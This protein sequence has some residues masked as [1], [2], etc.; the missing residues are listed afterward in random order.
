[1]RRRSRLVRTSLLVAA[2][3]LTPASALAAERVEEPFTSASPQ[4][5]VLPSLVKIKVPLPANTA[6]HPAACD[7][8]QYVRW[9][10]ADGPTSSM[11]ADAVAVLMPGILEG[12]MAFDVLARNVVRAAAREGRHVEVWGLDR[13]ANC[14]EDLTGVNAYEQSG[15]LS[16]VLG[17]YWHGKSV[18]GK[19]FAGFDRYNRVLRDIGMAQT[20][21]DYYSVL[22][23]E[24]PSQPWRESHV[25]CGGHSLG[26]PITQIFAG[27]DFDGN[28]ATTDDAGYR[29]C[30]GFVGFESTLDLDP[31]N[32]TPW[33]KGL[34]GAVFLGNYG[35]ARQAGNA[36]IKAGLLP[37]RAD[38]GGAD[39]RSS[40]FL[41]AAGIGASRD[42]NGEATALLKGIPYSKT[43]YDYFHFM[44]SSSI[45]SLMFTKDSIR[46]YRYT[47]MGLVGQLLDDNGAPFSAVRSSFGFFDGAP[48]RRNLLPKQMGQIPVVDWAFQ[49]NQMY[50]P[51]KPN[52]KTPLLGWKNYDQVG[53]PGQ[54][55]YKLTTPST[56]VSDANDIARILHEGPTNFTEPYM[57]MR[58]LTDL[59]S[60]Y[61]GDRGGDLAGFTYQHPTAKKP[62]MESLGKSGVA[63]KARLG[64]PDPF[65]MNEG[66]EHVDSITAAERQNNGK[67]EGSSKM[68]VDMI[69]KVAPR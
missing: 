15:D 67:P 42:P 39:P 61:G 8:L 46:Q 54:P 16:D 27:W 26:G 68:V 63:N 31:T 55:G 45:N 35:A 22:T 23:E 3:L 28:K 14:L 10:S 13:R 29:Q 2:S 33:L 24:L 62:R 66:Y 12:A 21:R 32:D 51:V 60:W 30:A 36:A 59:T 50:M 17:Y 1:M 43:T 18:A 4:A 56:E 69:D 52:G 58:I 48:I 25:L 38:L 40:V 11:D 41:E 7:W 64:S 37:A 9:R 47:N 49:A 57:P 20:V 34:I 19:T 44:G 53:G 6:A 5:D 65:V